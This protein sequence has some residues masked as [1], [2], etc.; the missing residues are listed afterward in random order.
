MD[1]PES[2]EICKTMHHPECDKNCHIKS[3]GWDI[4]NFSN[5]EPIFSFYDI[6]SHQTKEIKEANE[7]VQ[8]FGY[9]DI[10]QLAEDAFM[11]KF[12]YQNE[13]Q[14]LFRDIDRV[15]VVAKRNLPLVSIN[16]FGISISF[17]VSP[18]GF[19]EEISF[20][21]IHECNEQSD[22]FRLMAQHNHY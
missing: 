19:K 3:Y 8:R 16:V 13:T 5:T 9:Q 21:V 7:I 14:K 18:V 17:E 22:G 15:S 11:I 6:K 20:I 4:S 12:C 2:E 1:L 10:Y